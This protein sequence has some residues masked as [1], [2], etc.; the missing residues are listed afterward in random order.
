[1]KKWLKR[2]GIILL[3]ILLVLISILMYNW[4]DRHPYYVVDLKIEAATTPQTITAG[5]SKMPITPTIVD[6]WND[7]NGDFQYNEKDGDSYN[8]VNN[9]GTFDA[10]WIAG[11]SN[12]KPAQ[13]VHDDVWSRVMVIDDGNSKI[14]L[15]SMDAIGFLH[16]DVVDIREMIPEELGIDYVLLSSTHTHESND[17]V[18][19]WG[20]SIFKTGVNAEAM[21]YVKS[22]TVAA[23]EEAAKHMKSAHLIFAEDLSGED[24]QF[25]KDTRKPIV[26]AT[27]IHL[28]QVIDSENNTTLGSIV[29]WSNHPETLWSKNLLISSDFPH[30]VREAMENGIYNDD[31]ELVQKGL[32]GVSIY[33]SGVIGGL[34]APH[35]SLG[36]QDMHTDSVYF[37]PTFE[38]TKAIGD[39]IARLSLNALK[40]KGD[41]VKKANI[42]LRA[43]TLILP[44]ENTLFKIAGGLGVI[45]RGLPSLFTTRTEIGAIRIG[46]AMFLSIP[47]ELY[48]E[49]AFGGIEA[50]EGRDFD[51][52]PLEIPPLQEVIKDTYKFYIGLSNDLIGYIIPKS[53]WDVGKP[54]LYNDHG[55][56]YGEENSL[57]PDTAPILYKEL[58]SVIKDLD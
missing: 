13:G 54:Y 20:G 49:I 58:K 57:G 33:F 10:F 46:P 39:Q 30:Y 14:A 40:E 52:Q 29:N 17:L 12:K 9:N 53:E 43:K 18:G 38:K 11:M 34:M 36:I 27:G 8:D 2:V 6:T 41:T 3:V 22:Q 55:D 16:D 42:S 35:P 44:L 7:V 15:I 31:G 5:F 50:P 51:I 47:G 19:I 26:K 28:I 32:G 21:K 25:I 37:K 4:R 1:M 56:T 23:V 45:K 48:P 24:G